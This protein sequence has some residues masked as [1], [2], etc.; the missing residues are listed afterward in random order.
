MAV[1]LGFRVLFATGVTPLL[2][3][4]GYMILDDVW[5]AFGL[6][7]RPPLKTEEA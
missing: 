3:P 4:C 2:V 1:G 7:S 6:E 5:R